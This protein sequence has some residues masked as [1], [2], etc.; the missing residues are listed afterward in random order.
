MRQLCFCEEGQH[1]EVASYLYPCYNRQKKR[2][3]VRTHHAVQIYLP[4][5]HLSWP[6]YR[7][8]CLGYT[9]EIAALNAIAMPHQ[10][11]GAHAYSVGS[12]LVVLRT[13]VAPGNG[14]LLRVVA[15]SGTYGTYLI[16]ASSSCCRISSGSC[17]NNTVSNTCRTLLRSSSSRSPSHDLSSTEAT[18]HPNHLHRIHA[19]HVLV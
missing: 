12:G 17:R 3:G 16:P 10:K 4:P 8:K 6:T 9:R 2:F 18:H 7:C 13:P 1:G 19:R 5:D 11:A 15:E 14:Q